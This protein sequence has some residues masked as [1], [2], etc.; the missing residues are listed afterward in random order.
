VG[1]TK[2]FPVFLK[3]TVSLSTEEASL[4]ND[5]SV[6]IAEKFQYFVF[7]SSVY[8][9]NPTALKIALDKN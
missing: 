4:G 3:F 9:T 8:K 6:I 2:V 1:T 7:V 5:I